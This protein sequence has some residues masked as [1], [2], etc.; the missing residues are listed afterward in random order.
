[1]SDLIDRDKTLEA[2][3]KHFNP[4]GNEIENWLVA[5]TLIGVGVVISTM[6]TVDI[7]LSGYSDRLWKGAHERGKQDA[8][9]AIVRCKDCKYAHMTMDGECKYCDIWFPDEPVYTEGD[10]YC[11]SGERRTDE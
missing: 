4:G 5:E 8:M 2:I 3:Q 9:A 10:Y 7:D 6:P 11:A 1:M